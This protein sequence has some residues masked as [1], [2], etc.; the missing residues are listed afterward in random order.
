MS[1][2][3]K[4]FLFFVI[5]FTLFIRN[6]YSEVVNKI[7]VSGNDRVSKETIAVFGDISIGANY[8]SSDINLIIKKLYDSNFFSD[9]S[10]QLEN[11][12]LSINVKENPII[13]SIIFDGEK[14]N[15]NKDAISLVLTLK[16]SVCFN[17]AS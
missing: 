12:L 3:K 6:S 17:V 10:V 11:G 9:I 7:E 2:F 15:K 1:K 5:L 8:D 16:G 13:D 14:A 4:I